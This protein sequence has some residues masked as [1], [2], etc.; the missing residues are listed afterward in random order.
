[1]KAHFEFVGLPITIA[2]AKL[3]GPGLLEA[4]QSDKKA[5]S[6]D[7][8]LILAHGIGQAFVAN[9]IDRDA[10]AGFLEDL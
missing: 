9:H 4:M 5:R 3:E 6:S 8:T 1:V 7:L 2:E 10:L